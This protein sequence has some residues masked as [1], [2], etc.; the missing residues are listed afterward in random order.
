[1]TMSTYAL[2]FPNL[3][4]PSSTAIVQATGAPN[5]L[6]NREYFFNVMFL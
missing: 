5:R 6:S 1:M 2:L 3:R 4:M